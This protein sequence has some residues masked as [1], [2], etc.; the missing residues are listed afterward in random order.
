MKHDAR[1]KSVEICLSLGVPKPTFYRY[2]RESASGGAMKEPPPWRGLLL[3][4]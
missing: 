3:A 2:V 1:G 4:R